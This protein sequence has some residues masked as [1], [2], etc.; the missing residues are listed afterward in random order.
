[1]CSNMLLAEGWKADFINEELQM[2]LAPSTLQGNI[3]QRMRWACLQQE[4]S[5]LK[6][7]STDLCRRQ[8]TCRLRTLSASSCQV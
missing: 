3:K 6:F 5:L 4:D 2:N 7:Q 8:A 1:M